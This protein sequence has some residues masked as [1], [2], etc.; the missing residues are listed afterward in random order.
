MNLPRQP[1][2]V[3]EKGMGHRILQVPPL[4]GNESIDLRI[5]ASSTMCEHSAH[6][7]DASSV[8]DASS[9]CQSNLVTNTKRHMS[10]LGL[11]IPETTY[12]DFEV[13]EDCVF[14]T[15]EEDVLL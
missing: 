9:Y 14:R 1:V 11:G 10:T 12:K 6:H 5:L 8:T 15:V 4:Q 3:K 13:L 7:L 2:K